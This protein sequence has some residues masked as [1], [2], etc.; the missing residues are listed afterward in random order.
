MGPRSTRA[1]SIEKWTNPVRSSVQIFQISE[2]QQ[3]LPNASWGQFHQHFTCSFYVLRSKKAQK[4]TDVLTEF[5][6]FW[7]LSV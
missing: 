5:L 1:N 4:G 6:R 3:Q 7:D 2:Q